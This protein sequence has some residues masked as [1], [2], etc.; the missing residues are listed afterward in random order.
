MYAYMKVHCPICMAEF[1]GMKGG[2]GR[3]ARCCDRECWDE[4]EWRYTLSWQAVDRDGT[5][6]RTSSSMPWN[7]AMTTNLEEPHE[8]NQEDG[9]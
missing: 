8:T 5:R 7:D 2:C 4:W 3:Q 9:P 1:D 6:T